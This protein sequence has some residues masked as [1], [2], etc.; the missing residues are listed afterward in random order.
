MTTVLTEKQAPTRLNRRQ[1]YRIAMIQ[2]LGVAIE[3]GI[4]QQD[5]A[6]LKDVSEF[7]CL[8]QGHRALTLGE[9]FRLV[10]DLPQPVCITEARVVWTNGPR[11]GV[12]F[13]R[14]SPVERA[15]LWRFLWKHLGQA[16]ATDLQPLI[17]ITEE[18]HYSHTSLTVAP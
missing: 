13:V 16:S 1:T 18:P 14:I 17:A 5:I 6:T 7:G 3:R 10:L 4:N 11:C 8:I 9:R 15:R 2:P 12:E